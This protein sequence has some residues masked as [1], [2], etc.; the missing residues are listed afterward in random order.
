V[1]PIINSW[2]PADCPLGA[3][4]TASKH[5]VIGLTKNT[6]AQY[7]KQKIRCNAILPG[8]MQTNIGEALASGF[9]QAGYQICMS[10]AAMDPGYV[11]LKKVAALVKFL[12]SDDASIVNGA[13]VTADNGWLSY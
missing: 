4:Y 1:L 8:M 7:G 13:C 5:G 2:N 9:N 6:A 3:A 12:S 10:T 11:D